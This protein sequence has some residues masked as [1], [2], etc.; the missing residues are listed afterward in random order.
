LFSTLSHP[1][2]LDLID[3]I[4]RLRATLHRAGIDAP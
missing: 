1:W 2:L 4:E 3:E